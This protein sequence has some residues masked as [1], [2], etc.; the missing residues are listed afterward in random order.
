MNSEVCKDE[1]ICYKPA[2]K[3][4]KLHDPPIWIALISLGERNYRP[5]AVYDAR[6]ANKTRNI[7]SPINVIDN[8]VRH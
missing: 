1:W 6:K 4:C 3:T 2:K 5:P 8:S 7:F